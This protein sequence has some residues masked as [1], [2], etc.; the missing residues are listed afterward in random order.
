MMAKWSALNITRRNP[1][2]KSRHDYLGAAGFVIGGSVFNSTSFTKLVANW[3][4]PA[5]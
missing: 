2:F 5:S 4:P 1:G 3:L